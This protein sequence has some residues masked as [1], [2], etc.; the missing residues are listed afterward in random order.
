TSGTAAVAALKDTT[1]VIP[2]VFANAGDPV[3]TGLVTSLAHPS[4]N[5]TGLSLQQT[6]LAAK[7]LE[8]LRNLVPGLGRLAILANTTSAAAA[9]DMNEVGRTAGS[10]GLEVARV[11]I[12]RAEDLAPAFESLKGRVGA[13]YV[14]LDPLINANRIAISGLA[15]DARLPTMHSFKEAAQDGGLL[16]YGP[17]A[18]A[19]FQRAAE[20]VDKILR[21]VGPNELPVEQPTKFEL[22]INLKTAKALGITVPPSLSALADEVIE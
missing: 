13:V 16:S 12:G 19:M 14:V 20:Y 7:R 5:I 10:L 4:G 18:A 2:I 6:D 17:N 15:L 3:S 22:I 9:L 8:I 1:T 11:E 21:G